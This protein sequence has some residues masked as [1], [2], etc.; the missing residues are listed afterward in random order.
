MDQGGRLQ[1][2]AGSFRSHL[3]LGKFAKFVVD[4]RP[5]PILRDRVLN[6]LFLPLSR[7]CEYDQERNE[8]SCQSRRRTAPHSDAS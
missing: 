1:S 2:M 7:I 4:Q 3:V 8:A 6:R 5:Q